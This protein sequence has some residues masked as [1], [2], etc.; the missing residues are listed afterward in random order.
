MKNYPMGFIFSD[1]PIENIPD[2]YILST[3]LNQYYYYYD[4]DCAQNVKTKSNKFII[5]HGYYKYI[6]V[7]NDIDNTNLLNHLLNY[8]FEDYEKFLNTIDFI[9]GRYV[10]IVGNSEQ[11]EFYQD[12]T[13][14]RSVYYSLDLNLV[15]THAHLLNQAIPHQLS[16]IALQIPSLTIS[17]DFTPYNRIRSMTPNSNLN[18][19]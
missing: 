16:Q 14:A 18:L 12:A 17:W 1:S 3:V 9:S 7:V 13:G 11:V 19:F 10:I 8:Y 4:N 5:I 6:N 2:H 15:S